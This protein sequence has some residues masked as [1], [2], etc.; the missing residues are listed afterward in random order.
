MPGEFNHEP[1]D[2]LCP[3]CA[4][5]N[6]HEDE[7][8]TL[9]DIVYQ[10]EHVTAKIAPKWW[11]DNPGNVLVIPN[12]HYENIYDIPEDV[13]TEVY[14]VVKKIAIAIRSTYGCDGMSTRQ[15][16]EPAGNQ[17]VWHFHVHVF[18]R[19]KDDNLYL[20]HADNRFATGEERAPYALRLREY[21]ARSK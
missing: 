15:H 20:N 19:Y 9:N 21:F 5:L 18:P 14:K 2:Y 7:F 4:L 13:M 11:V 8:A 10:N 12:K 16:N 17:D 1:E 3:F 6:G